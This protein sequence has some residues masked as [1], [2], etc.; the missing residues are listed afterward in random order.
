MNS[1]RLYNAHLN[2]MT[3]VSQYYLVLHQIT[4]R[5]KEDTGRAD[6]RC[7]MNVTFHV[8]RNVSGR[9]YVYAA[10]TEQR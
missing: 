8:E 5:R 2:C 7:S 9:V 10:E 3:Q 4:R 1:S 6:A